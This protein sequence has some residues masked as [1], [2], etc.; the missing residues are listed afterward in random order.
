MTRTLKLSSLKPYRL[1]QTNVLEQLPLRLLA[2]EGWRVAWNE[3][4]SECD[5]W[6]VLDG[7]DSPDSTLCPPENTL[8]VSA[9]PSAYKPYQGDWLKSFHRVV[10]VQARIVHPGLEHGH[11][12]LPWF[13]KRSLD[14]L[15]L[16]APQPKSAPISTVCSSR[17]NMLGHRRRLRCL[18]ALQRR[19]PGRIEWYGRK[20][21]FIE[22]KWEGLAPFRF[23]L[24]IE[25]SREPHYWTEKISDC[26][27]ARTVPLYDGAPNIG[28][29]FPEGAY[30]PIDTD[31]PDSVVQTISDILEDPEALYQR[32]LP[33]VE[34]ARRRYL[35]QHSFGARLLGWCRA[36][37]P[38]LNRRHVNLAPEPAPAWWPSKVIKF[39]RRWLGVT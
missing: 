21:R 34:E 31:D 23:S 22:D 24:A 12:P 17:H 19:L 11:A 33:A 4:V 38:G 25:N 30:V 35:D 3:P 5:A 39:R 28:S 15:Q 9:E 6:V 8:F 2:A 10:S 32:M 18:R 36:F 26:F 27:L 14:C 13:P 29:Y 37:Q 1:P 20:I 16:E 7:L